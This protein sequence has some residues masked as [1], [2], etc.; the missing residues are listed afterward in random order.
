MSRPALE[1]LADQAEAGNAGAQWE[2]AYAHEYG[3]VDG[4]GGVLQDADRAAAQR[5]YELAARQGH[6]A[7]QASLSTF[8]SDPLR[9]TPQ[10]AEA[11]YWGEQAA[12]QGDAMAAYNTGLIH[13]DLG[14]LTQAMAWY[15]RAA[16]LGDREALLQTALCR[17]FGIGTARNVAQ[18]QQELE[19]LVQAPEDAVTPRGREHA[20]CWLAVLT[21]WTS[22]DDAVRLPDARA[23]L[24]TANVD[25]DHEGAQQLLNLIGRKVHRRHDCATATVRTRQAL[26]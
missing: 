5:W 8:L 26:P 7:A 24:A 14:D 21:L 16:A 2:L 23:L 22:T 25:E 20:H 6:S 10:W 1:A 11:L 18:A 19:A 15:E 4:D 12:K 13:R 17:L 9:G 3:A